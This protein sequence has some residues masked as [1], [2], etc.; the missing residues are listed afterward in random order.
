MLA[1]S[2]DGGYGAGRSID[3]A[4][5]VVLQVGDV[6]VT[7]SIERGPVGRGDLGMDGGTV[8]AGVPLDAASGDGVDDLGDGVYLADA[9]V[10]GVGNEQVALAIT[11]N[12]H[13][14]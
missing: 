2:H 6:D 10:M 13:G 3:P 8:I 9:G 14:M 5:S 7:M 12:S 11:R 1:V 4:D